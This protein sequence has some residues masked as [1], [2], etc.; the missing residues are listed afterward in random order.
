MPSKTQ[1]SGKRRRRAQ[2]S[3][4]T[5]NTAISLLQSLTR[6]TQQLT[7]A[8]D[9]KQLTFSQAMA[10]AG[11][12]RSGGNIQAAD[13]IYKQLL[14]YATEWHRTGRLDDAE[15]A[16]REV[17][18]ARPIYIDALHLL[19]VIYSQRGDHAT[20]ERLIRQ[21]VREKPGTDTYLNNLGRAL[22]EQKRLAEA[23]ECYRSALQ[24]NPEH[25]LACNN[26]GNVHAALGEW[27]SAVTAYRRALELSPNFDEARRNLERALQQ[28]GDAGT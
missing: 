9:G 20:A 15:L 6:G 28:S 18:E 16:Y 10:L 12:L 7:V 22:Q 2:N 8:V 4:A 21:A 27:G 14:E 24:I 13:T 3:P 19:G 11:Q 26:L 1:P 5:S 25:V 17:F 23:G